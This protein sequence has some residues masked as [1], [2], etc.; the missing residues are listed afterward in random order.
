M[1]WTPR[2]ATIVTLI[3]LCFAAGGAWYTN[4][5]KITAIANN[6]DPANARITRQWG[7]MNE[8]RQAEI[9]PKSSQRLQKLE[10]HMQ[11]IRED[12]NEIKGLVQDLHKRLK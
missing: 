10:T 6:I 3:L 2:P 11:Y 8:H 5:F 9:H 7:V 4:D 1:N 12:V